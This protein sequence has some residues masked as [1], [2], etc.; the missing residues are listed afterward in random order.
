MNFQFTV[1]SYQLAFGRGV[2]CANSG[3][4]ISKR[5]TREHSKKLIGS[6]HT[7]TFVHA[8]E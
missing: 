6:N 2:R 8:I 7:Q 1:I 3:R 4:E 5:G